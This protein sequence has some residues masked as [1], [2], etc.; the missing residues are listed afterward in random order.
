MALA[1]SGDARALGRLVELISGP[2]Y[3]FGRRFC[4][5]PHDAEDVT[6]TVLMA[7]TRTFKDFRGDSSLTTWAYT[8]A[9]HACTRQRRRSAGAPSR[10]ESLDDEDSR[11]DARSV[12][13]ARHDPERELER[14]ELQKALDRAIAALPPPQR[15][16]LTLRDVE[17]L[18]ARE[19]G[20]ILGLGERAVKS[21]LHRAR[22]ALRDALTPWVE[23][24]SGIARAGRPAGSGRCPDTARMISRY[25][26]GDLD[27]ATCARLE[28]HVRDCPSCGVACESL[29]HALETCRAWRD[30]PMPVETVQWVRGALQEV[31]KAM[32]E[33][34]RRRGAGPDAD[35]GR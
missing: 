29:R 28:R 2:V 14:R 27:A 10:L 9:R 13:D 31:V 32:R 11:A 3:R 16:V 1:R 34:S 4:G 17:G 30:E 8:V 33:G 12:A 20:R 23:A 26:E 15:E 18:P 25:L 19:V 7:L 6:Q 35:P 5:D 22:L 24:R 21:R